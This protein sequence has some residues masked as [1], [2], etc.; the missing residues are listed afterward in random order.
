M[1]DENKVVLV[2]EDEPA[3][4]RLFHDL[5]SRFGYTVLLA[6]DGGQA[7]GMALDRKPDLI[8]M[9][10]GLPGMN[11]LDAT[12]AIRQNAN[13]AR[14]PIVALTAYAMT[15]DRT[16]AMQAG[17]NAFVVKPFDIAELMRVVRSHLANAVPV[18][19]EGETIDDD[20][21]RHG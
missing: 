2:V 5:L 13:T 14:I 17:C 3:N 8:L 9:D 10:I 6:I 21:G 4:Q 11:G 7:V 20:G 1:T 16:K 15:E 19:A 12:R 18:V